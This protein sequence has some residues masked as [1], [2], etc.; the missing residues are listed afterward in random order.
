[1]RLDGSDALLREAQGV[2][3]QPGLVYDVYAIGQSEDGTL[4]M[5]VLAANA[6]I[7][8]GMVAATGA[9]MAAP[10]ATP[11]AEA[12]PVIAVGATPVG[13]T[14]GAATPAATPVS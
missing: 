9:P 13:V 2:Q 6:G 11:A 5:V 7:Q 12:T 14:P 10:M 4:Q 8:Q 1:L 3:L